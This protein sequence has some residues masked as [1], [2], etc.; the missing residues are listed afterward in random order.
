MSLPPCSSTE[1]WQTRPDEGGAVAWVR[2][3][4]PSLL[5]HR[6]GPVT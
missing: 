5:P 1:C 3:A 2:E 4:L 6:T